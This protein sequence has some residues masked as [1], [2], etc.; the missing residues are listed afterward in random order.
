MK[1]LIGTKFTPIG[2]HVEHT[3]VDYY[4]T[5]NMAGDIVRERYVTTKVFCGQVVFDHD[6]CETTIAR[7]LGQNPI[8]SPNSNGH[9]DVF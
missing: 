7:A 1:F 3:V 5:K 4:V 2:R 9:N 8:P 6:V